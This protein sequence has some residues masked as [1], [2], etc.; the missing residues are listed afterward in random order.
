[1]APS[2]PKHPSA[3]RAIESLVERLRRGVDQHR[4]A[5]CQQSAPTEADR[6]ADTEHRQRRE[7][8]VLR[9][10]RLPAQS[11]GF[12]AGGA[13]RVRTSQE[14]GLLGH[15]DEN[16]LAYALRHGL[17]LLSCDRDFLNERK[18]SLVHCPALFVFDFGSGSEH[19]IRLAFRCL[20]EVLMD[21]QF[22]DKWWKYDVTPSGWT[23][24]TRHLDGTT[25][26]DRYRL[27]AGKLQIWR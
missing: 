3:L 23:V 1:M 10:R 20:R 27:H 21:P 14:A 5:R 9:G 25:S 24:S 4:N 2:G 19:E 15:P 7:A 8:E 16:H 11:D 17:V 13:V 12:A 22:Y 26:H 6:R 18:F